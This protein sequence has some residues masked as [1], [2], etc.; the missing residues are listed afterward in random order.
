MKDTL[1]DRV[2]LGSF[3]IEL[4]AGELRQG[5]GAVL[6]LPDQPLHILRMLIEADGEI[7]TRDQIRQR[8]WPDDTVVEFDHSIN[9]AIKKLRRA[10]VDS[11]DEPHY[12][13]TIAKRGYRLLVP[14]ERLDVEDAS[15]NVGPTGGPSA[16]TAAVATA[17]APAAA[18]PR[19]HAD[20]LAQASPGGARSRWRRIAIALLVCAAAIT[21]AVYWGAHRAPKLTERDTIVLGDFEN[22]TGDPVF[23][24]TLKQALTIQLT[25]SPFLN[26]LP[27]AK[28][29]QTL[30]EMS[31]PTSIPLTEEVTREVCIRTGSKAIVVGT[32]A[33]F[34]QEYVIGLKAVDCN[35]GDSMSEVQERAASKET[36]LPALD[37]AAA[38][39][40]RHL[41]E[42]LSSV[43]R[44]AAPLSHATT[45]S[46]DA[47]KA[48]SIGEK[49]AFTKSWAA[50]LPYYKRA[51][52][53]DPKFATAYESLSAI[54]QNLNEGGRALEYERQAYELRNTVGERERFPIEAN[55]YLNVTG[56]LDKAAATYELWL[57][58]Y[59]RAG[60]AYGNLGVVYGNL[61]RWDDALTVTKEAIRWNPNIGPLYLNL[62]SIYEALNRLQEAEDAYHQAKEH[63]LGSDELLANRYQLAFLKGDV[64]QMEQL[65]AAASGK[66]GMENLLL[67]F[68]ADTA[69]WYGKLTVSRQLSIRAIDSAER[70][71][72]KETAATY[73]AAAALRE[74]EM[75][76]TE[77]ARHEALA[78]VKLAPTRDVQAISALALARAGDVT[79][80]RNLAAALDKSFQLDTLVQRYWLP[81]IRAAT[82]LHDGDPKEAVQLLRATSTTELG[83]P[84]VF[85]IA[86]CPVYVRGQAYLTLRDGSSAAAEFQKFI[87]HRGVLVNF[88][89]GALARLGLARAYALE[90]QSDSTY[91]EKSRTAYQNFLTLWKDADPDIPIYKEAKAEYAKLQ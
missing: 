29:R 4:R 35:S 74:V 69:A 63:K 41:G 83:Q 54:Y 21:G 52:E 16:R 59:S 34:G 11:G 19:T 2:R 82:A 91:R 30:V 42:S 89:W 22:K 7:V 39:L 90:A 51:V 33:A 40:R 73:E 53:L 10:L 79:T 1:P 81:A 56:E 58:T 70:S 13:G 26:L 27:N 87:E 72:A 68:Q 37:K 45:P 8:L 60:S 12:I 17:A 20:V 5:E 25:E 43:E 44:Y 75:G 84:V 14:V 66:P 6:V 49:V 3:E 23:D 76:N 85:T 57:Q 48:Y 46:L 77:Q 28:L 65:A 9:N 88:P 67:A 80:A 18:E 50:A 55:Y 38:S 32:I 47:L 78:A 86:L 15:N 36:V 61:G 62:G 24:D 31:R 64:S 71:D